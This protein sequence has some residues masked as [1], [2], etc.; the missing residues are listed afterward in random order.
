MPRVYISPSTQEFNDFVNGGTEEYW[1]NRIADKLTPY[2]RSS[3]IEYTRN[4][5]EMTAASSLRQANQGYYDLYVAIHSNAAPEESAGQYRGTD[6]YYAPNS[7][8]GKWFASIVADNFKNIYPIPEKV[9]I[10]STTYLGEVTKT[11]APASL[12]EVAYHDNVEDANWIK[13]NIDEIARE[14]ALSI[15]EYFGLPLVDPQPKQ[16]GKVRTSGGNL[17]IRSKPSTSAAVLATAYNGAPITVL[18][19]YND[20]YVVNYQGITGYANA[21]FIDLYE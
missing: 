6:V 1:M 20:W 4:T 3:G 18:G 19:Q 11:K 15:A 16:Y 14:I 17:N 10:L 13:G 5:P 21:N 12:I 7:P 8:S 2:L 9:R